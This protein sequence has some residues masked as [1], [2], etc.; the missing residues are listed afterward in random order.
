[1]L[2]SR[3]V[4][5]LAG[6]SALREDEERLHMLI[7]FRERAVVPDRRDEHRAEIPEVVVDEGSNR[8]PIIFT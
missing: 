7:E 1:L 4:A 8:V 3:D 2:E 6:T 5:R